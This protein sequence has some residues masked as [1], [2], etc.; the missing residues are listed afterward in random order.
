MIGMSFPVALGAGLAVAVAAIVFSTR[1]RQLSS[2]LLVGAFVTVSLGVV[3]WSHEHSTTSGLTTTYVVEPRTSVDAS[4]P[5]INATTL[6]PA[7]AA[8]RT[9]EDGAGPNRAPSIAS[10]TAAALMA[11]AAILLIRRRREMTAQG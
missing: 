10:F 6:E 1:K 8:A 2:W 5:V 4:R 11:G 7:A 9:V 3:L